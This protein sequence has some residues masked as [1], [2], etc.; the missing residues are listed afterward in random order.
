MENYKLIEFIVE[1]DVGAKGRPRFRK[2]GNYVQTYTDKKTTSYEEHVRNCYFRKYPENQGEIVFIDNE[3]ISMEICAYVRIPESASKK[4][5]EQMLNC[6]IYPTKKPDY[7][8]IMKIISDALNGICFYDDKQI[9]EASFKK[10]YST[11]PKVRVIIHNNI[12]NI[13]F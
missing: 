6:D 1:G 12:D 2:F 5:K 10:I 3:P 13:P 9:V 7:D 11:V 4:K 8:N